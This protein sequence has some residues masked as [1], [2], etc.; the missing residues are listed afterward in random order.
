MGFRILV[1]DDYE[2][3]RSFVAS[4]LKKQPDFEIIGEA[5]DG[6]IAVQKAEELQPD[7][8]LLD[9]GLPRLNGIEVARQVRTLC[10][11]S[12]ILMAT[13]HSA[14]ELV[15]AA[16]SAGAHGYLLKSNAGRE[17]L[18]A[19]TNVLH[20]KQFVSGCL[21]DESFPTHRTTH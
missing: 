3:W 10:P 16:L 14:S 6:V 4:V 12:K 20:G 9:I 7:L 11:K 19:L 2:P 17:L 18:P 8:I 13:E 15:K 21:D 5:S 1:V